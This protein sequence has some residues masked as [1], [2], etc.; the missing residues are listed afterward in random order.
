MEDANGISTLADSHTH[1]TSVTESQTQVPYREAVG[2]LIFAAIIT[3]PD[4]AFAVG[5]VSRYVDKHGQPHWNSVKRIIRYLK[6][7]RDYG[8]LYSKTQ[9]SEVIHGFSDSDFAND[10]DTRRFTTG[11]TFKLSNGP[12]TWNSRCQSTVSLST[13]EAKYIAASR[14]TRE[15]M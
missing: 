12:V 4:I 6:N 2:S 14:A 15:V 7:T 3:R 11:Y 9:E 13:T 10:I 1:L 5:V 8:I